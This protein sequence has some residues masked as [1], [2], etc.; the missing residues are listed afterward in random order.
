M[1]RDCKIRR[2]CGPKADTGIPL[3]DAQLQWHRLALALIPRTPWRRR[4]HPLVTLRALFKSV[5]SGC[6][7]APPVA[8]HVVDCSVRDLR[9]QIDAG[10]PLAVEVL[11]FTSAREKVE[12]WL[13]RLGNHLASGHSANHALAAEPAIF[14][15]RFEALKPGPVPDIVELECLTP[16]A[17]RPLPGNPPTALS[18]ELFF[19]ELR[20]H[21]K[22][23]FGVRLLPPPLQR[24]H[25]HA[26]FWDY[27]RIEAP[28]RSQPGQTA[29]LHGCVGPLWFAGDLAPILPWLHL[30]AAIH[31][32][33]KRALNPLGYCRLHMKPRPHLD[34]VL[35]RPGFYR[36]VVHRLD[37]GSDRARAA[38]VM[39]GGAAGG[40]PS[41][42]N[43]CR[44]LAQSIAA[45][46]WEPP[47]N[48]AFP[49]P[50]ANG[51]RWVE[52]LE[53]ETQLVHMALQHLLQAPLDRLLSPA[54]VGFRPGR[55]VETAV[56]MVRE[57]VSAG[58]RH[59]V[60]TDIRD[61][62][63]SVD[64]RHLCECLDRILPPADAGLRRLLARC[65]T[66][67]RWKEGRL[68]PRVKGLAAGSPLSPLL[69]NV[70]LDE[71]DRALEDAPGRMVRYADDIVLLAKT[72]QAAAELFS[73][74][75]AAAEALGLEL[76]HDKTVMTD[77]E[78]GFEF[79][80]HRI[81][82]MTME[83]PEPVPHP[84]LRKT[85][86]VTEP[87]LLLR[88]N[89]AAIEVR[90]AGAPGGIFPLR[91]LNGV[92]VLAPGLLT[93]GVVRCCA[94]AAVPLAIMHGRRAP[95]MVF[96]AS[97]NWMATA[98]RQAE[99]WG[100]LG[101]TGRLAI[102]RRLVASK[103]SGYC[104]LLRQR[105]KPGTNTLLS[106][107]DSQISRLE[108][109][110]EV[111]AV[112]G[113]EGAAARRIQRAIDDMIRNPAFRFARRGRNQP[114]R[115]NALLNFA[116]HL[117]YIRLSGLLHSAGLDPWLGYLHDANDAYESLTCDLQEIFRAPVDRMSLA[118]I[119]RREVRRE[120]FQRSEGGRYRMTAQGLRQVVGGFE[121][122]LHDQRQKPT[123]ADAMEAQVE[124]LRRYV[125]RRGSLWIF[126]WGRRDG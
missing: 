90:K 15:E 18:T 111:G 10:R 115:T 92:V 124:A 80:G 65:L 71:F 67:P 122:M 33:G 96:P 44:E 31:A 53:P 84:P 30:A 74:A 82:G 25:L 97:R 21:V 69:M 57:A 58:Y 81:D 109:A 70:Y 43:P 2:S 89:G 4:S 36:R 91:R 50:K 73:R 9:R 68:E 34:R 121:T 116:Y 113:H 48:H 23:L 37:Q 22:A 7:D 83:A 39:F 47:P 120:H 99:H 77:A 125:L 100:S 110:G 27:H 104:Y 28:S 87:G 94:S 45:G 40:G 118:L 114:D 1:T 62:F 102:A 103:L 54:A 32:G 126:C 63:D 106:F 93:T 123:L 29:W 49:I 105:Y 108:T 101:P 6:L 60:K 56:A 59:V 17:F 66:A 12:E 76:S 88:Q 98:S 11:L 78:K 51:V 107:L 13:D 16:L 85:L 46:T 35:G 55:S 19:G 20:A 112:R 42:G 72:R 52:R 3:A 95:G 61:C 119:N 24:L 86:F 5:T 26:E 79:L 41:A 117:L 75:E 38:A 14:R 64:L 8:F